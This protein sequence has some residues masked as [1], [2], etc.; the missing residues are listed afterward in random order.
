MAEIIESHNAAPQAALISKLNPIIRG[1]ANY[2]STVVSKETFS[3]I[4][5][6][7]WK[8]LE[9]WCK[10][11]HPN[12]NAYYAMNKYFKSEQ[13]RNWVFRD[14]NSKL[15]RHSDTPIIRHIKVKDRKSPYD[16]DMAYWASRIGRHPELSTRVAKLLRTQKGKCI[17][18]KLTFK[19]GDIWEVDHIIPRSQ[20]GKDVY[21]NLQLLHR[22]CHDVKTAKDKAGC[23]ND[24]GQLI[25]EPCEAKVSSTVLKTSRSGDGMA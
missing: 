16:G 24:N 12:K 8:R 1:W 19:D 18:C 25:E 23:T 21:N 20:G 5:A 2:Y 3:K 13:N 14:K 22:H 7:I 11:R 9:R 17:H 4:D 10:R 15:I 6:L